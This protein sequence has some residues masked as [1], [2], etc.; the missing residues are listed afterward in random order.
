MSP[1]YVRPLQDAG[2]VEATTTLRSPGNP[3]PCR[4]VV[5]VTASGLVALRIAERGKE[6][7]FDLYEE[8]LFGPD[9]ARG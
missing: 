1:E 9:A 3:L 5:R 7:A 2:F 8:I 4:T 6:K